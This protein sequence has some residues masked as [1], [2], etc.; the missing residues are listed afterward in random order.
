MK[1]KIEKIEKIENKNKF[2]GNVGIPHDAT[3]WQIELNQKT[4][5]YRGTEL[6]RIK[7]S[8]PLKNI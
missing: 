2:K 1:K 6:N 5:G 7:Q 3:S 4:L 8:K